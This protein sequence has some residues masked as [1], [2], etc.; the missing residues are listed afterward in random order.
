MTPHASIGTDPASEVEEAVAAERPVILAHLSPGGSSAVARLKASSGARIDTP[1]RKTFVRSPTDNSSVRPPL[2]QLFRRGGR[3][4]AVPLKLYLAI[5]W[6][7]SGG[8]YDTDISARQ[9]AAVLD[10]PDPNTAG[11][12]R[13]TDALE[14]LEAVR[15]VALS[16]RRGDS[17]VVQLLAESGSGAAYSTPSGKI[18]RGKVKPDDPNLF[19][20]VPVDL[21]LSGHLQRMDAPAVAMLLILLAEQARPA[22]PAWFATE[23]FPARYHLSSPVRSRGTKEL[24]DRGLLQVTKKLVEGGAQSYGRERVRNKYALINEATPIVREHRERPIQGGPAAALSLDDF[25]RQFEALKAPQRAA[26]D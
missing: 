3:G 10:L 19:F 8:T 9:F 26:K 11:A 23:I 15:V 5:L 13:I 24:S 1:L 4:P 12:R 14:R 6:R 18:A 21:W 7:C 22:H 17:T 2:A 25:I 20:K 16:K